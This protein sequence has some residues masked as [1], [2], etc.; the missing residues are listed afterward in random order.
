M[1][2]GARGTVI[3]RAMT[4][5]RTIVGAAIIWCVFL[6]LAIGNGVLRDALLGRWLSMPAAQRASVFTLI[7][8]FAVVV[9]VA[10]RW[11]RLHRYPTALLVGVAWAAATV[12]FEAFMV[13]RLMQRPWADVLGQ[14]DLSGG[15]LWVF[16]PASLIGLPLL[17][18]RA[19]GS[20]LTTEGAACEAPTRE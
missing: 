5:T 11:W 7:G 20:S 16:V 15:N 10:R 17:A 6:V 9:L 2:D 18:M 12:A 1:R 19:R 4:N 14:Y 3:R 8:A 13:V